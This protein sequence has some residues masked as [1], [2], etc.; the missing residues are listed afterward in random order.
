MYELFKQTTPI[1][2]STMTNIL[3]PT[4][5]EINLP[6]NDFD[7]VAYLSNLISQL[8]EIREQAIEYR[9]VLLNTLTEDDR[10]KIVPM[11]DARKTTEILEDKFKEEL[12]ETYKRCMSISP[13]NAFKI[14]GEDDILKLCLKYGGTER[15]L[16]NAKITL[17]NMR[18][19]L[20]DDEFKRYTHEYHKVI[21]KIM[22]QK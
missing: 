2:V 20:S 19:Y 6:S 15:T 7:K 11:F 16:Q 18:K 12:P 9:D 22:V 21:G 8:D 13:S 10:Y 14:I 17:K 3:Q 1:D 5:V 4:K